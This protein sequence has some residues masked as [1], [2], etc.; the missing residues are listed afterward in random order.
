MTRIIIEHG[1]QF[2]KNNYIGIYAA[3][4]F[5]KFE[6]L[7]SGQMLKSYE[8]PVAVF[9]TDKRTESGTHWV[10]MCVLSNDEILVFDSLGVIGFSNFF[11]DDDVKVLKGIISDDAFKK[12]DDDGH[13]DIKKFT[14]DIAAYKKLKHKKNLSPYCRGI[15]EMIISLSV[16]KD[17]NK[18]KTKFAYNLEQIQN[19]N[20]SFCG[21]YCLMFMFKT[22]ATK[23][24]IT[25]DHCVKTANQLFDD[26]KDTKVDTKSNSNTKAADKFATKY[27]VQGDFYFNPNEDQ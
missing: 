22:Y 25:L 16:I 17:K 12:P 19:Q 23:K 6:R 3:D 5:K 26:V 4:E 20:T 21:I 14:I 13:I 10:V 2:L 27:K 24:A 1:S 15:I 11:V 8:C 18:K 7:A 9:N